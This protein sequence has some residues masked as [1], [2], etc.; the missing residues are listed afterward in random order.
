[1]DE[2]HNFLLAKDNGSLVKLYNNSL[3]EGHPRFWHFILFAITHLSD[4]I[5]VLQFFHLSIVILCCILLVRYSPLPLITKGLF[6]FGYYFIYEY[7][8][9]SRSYSLGILVLFIFYL[10]FKN[11][12]RNYLWICFLLLILCNIHLYYAF[13]A[14]GL[15]AI[16]AV[17]KLKMIFI[18]PNYYLGLVIISVGLL[19]LLIQIQRL[20]DASVDLDCHSFFSFKIMAKYFCVVGKVFFPISN[21]SNSYFWN[22]FLLNRFY[23]VIQLLIGLVLIIFPWFLYRKNTVACVFFY[24]GTF[25]FLA[26]TYLSQ[27]AAARYYGTVFILFIAAYW[28]SIYYREEIDEHEKVKIF[29]KKNIVPGLLYF[30]LILNICAGFYAVYIDIKEPFS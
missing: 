1:M 16:I 20:G 4:N 23:P 14:V 27:M 24:S 22:D 15:F 12:N 21:S 29:S 25:L 7:S 13:V 26:C 2:A 3:Y 8:I 28:I 5:I 17:G 6:I 11:V 9:F 10:L 18:I 30:I 19:L